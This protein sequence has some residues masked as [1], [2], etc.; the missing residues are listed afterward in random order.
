MN[1]NK[2]INIMFHKLIVPRYRIIVKYTILEM[3]MR[4]NNQLPSVN[5]T[6]LSN[7]R[8]KIKNIEQHMN[9]PPKTFNQFMNEYKKYY[10]LPMDEKIYEMMENKM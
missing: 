10:S 7:L 2:A 9:N 1:T 6:Y 8:K 5:N 4:L 3:E